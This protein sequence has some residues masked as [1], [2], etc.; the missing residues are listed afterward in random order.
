MCCV[1]SLQTLKLGLRD[2]ACKI[3]GLKSKE[4][5]EKVRNGVYSGLKI[6][7]D[8]TFRNTRE[9]TPENQY[10]HYKSGTTETT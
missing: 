4:K 7:G 10:Y 1:K 5:P 9:N 2:P 8:D 6:P 3:V